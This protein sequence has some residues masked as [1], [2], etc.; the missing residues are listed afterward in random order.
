[1]SRQSA[2]EKCSRCRAMP[3]PANTRQR[4]GTTERGTGHRPENHTEKLAQPGF[5]RPARHSLWQP[6]AIFALPPQRDK[7]TLRRRPR[8]V[9]YTAKRHQTPDCSG[10]NIKEYTQLPSL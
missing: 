9:P 2:A 6:A 7:R 8:V 1:M 10:C 4:S 5:N 3:S